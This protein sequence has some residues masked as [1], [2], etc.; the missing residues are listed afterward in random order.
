M[1]QSPATEHNVVRYEPFQNMADGETLKK[2]SSYFTV[3]LSDSVV[4]I[5]G[6][7]EALAH[8]IYPGWLP[9]HAAQYAPLG[10]VCHDSGPCV[11][12]RRSEAVGWVAD[13]EADDRLSG[14]I[15]YLVVVEDFHGLPWSRSYM[16]QYSVS[17]PGWLG[18]TLEKTHLPVYSSLNMLHN[19]SCGFF[20]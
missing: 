16:C 8:L 9:V 15:S 5:R 11:G 18:R 13:L 6:F 2:D 4:A 12:V 7:H 3:V 10:D 1:C 20:V 17:S 19:D 14:R